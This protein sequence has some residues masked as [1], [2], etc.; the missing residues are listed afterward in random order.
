M[1]I[2]TNEELM[3]FI[4]GHLDDIEVVRSFIETGEQSFIMPV[5]GHQLYK[6]LVDEYANFDDGKCNTDSDWKELLIRVQRA[7]ANYAYYKA[8]P[9]LN[10]TFVSGGGAAVMVS[11][12][13]QIA[14]KDRVNDVKTSVYDD[15]HEGIDLLIEL[16]EADAASESPKFK[17]MWMESR[18]CTL[19]ANTLIRTATEFDRFVHIG[20]SRVRFNA[21]IPDVQ[22]CEDLFVR[23][24]LGDALTDA[25]ITHSLSPDKSPEGNGYSRIL[26]AV[27][28]ALALFTASR[29]PQ[30]SR[31]T[32]AVD[33]RMLLSDVMN[34]VTS[35]PKSFP[36]FLPVKDTKPNEETG[37]P[38]ANH[39]GTSHPDGCRGKSFRMGFGKIGIK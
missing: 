23:P 35:D 29:D 13:A 39:H 9:K 20:A 27:C 32:Q 1:L 36:A 8:I 19:N 2:R 26:P 3:A 15:A 21:L 34:R 18:W 25:L 5:L 10:V 22:C 14:S 12:R 38:V 37:S 4:P 6:D 17:D 16:L 33:A 28:R 11:D 31:P 24:A 30:L 7:L